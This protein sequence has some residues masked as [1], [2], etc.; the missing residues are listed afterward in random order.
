MHMAVTTPTE[1]IQTSYSNPRFR[2]SRSSF[3]LR[4]IPVVEKTPSENFRKWP[5]AP[6]GL[7]R[8]A[9]DS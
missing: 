2:P 9:L 7:L 3:A 4:P 6:C 5:K 8:L 1:L